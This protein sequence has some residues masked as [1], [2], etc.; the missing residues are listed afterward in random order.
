MQ[1]RHRGWIKSP[2]AGA[3]GSLLS[4]CFEAVPPD[5]TSADIRSG[6]QNRYPR[7]IFFLAVLYVACLIGYALVGSSLYASLFP[8]SYWGPLVAPLLLLLLSCCCCC[9]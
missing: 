4:G 9:L 5:G 3:N 7:A 1:L 2:I 6:P 8:D